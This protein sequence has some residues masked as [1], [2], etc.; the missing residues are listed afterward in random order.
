MNWRKKPIKDWTIED[1]GACVWY[2]FKVYTL[3]TAFLAVGL[4]L[5]CGALPIILLI[6]SSPAPPPPTPT[7]TPRPVARAGDIIP[8]VGADTGNK[9][10]S[11]AFISWKESNIA[12]VG[13]YRGDEF[14]TFTAKPGMKFIIL[15]FEF[16][17][18]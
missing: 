15:I 17:N 5:L 9:S 3:A 4:I 14:Y 7:T 1:V 6:I 13:P 11:L 2:I 10:L 16:R 18:S 8:E 12:V